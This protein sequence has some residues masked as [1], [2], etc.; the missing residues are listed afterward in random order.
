MRT[1]VTPEGIGYFLLSSAIEA[2][3][4]GRTSTAFGFI[5]LRSMPVV[6]GYVK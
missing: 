3:T 5:V 6:L 1:E 4:S 2:D